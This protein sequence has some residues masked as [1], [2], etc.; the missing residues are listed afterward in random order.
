MKE[1]ISEMFSKML[2]ERLDV[3]GMSNLVELGGES[4]G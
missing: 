4:D 3:Y 1:K 2:I